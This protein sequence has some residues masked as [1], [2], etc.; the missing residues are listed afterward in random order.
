[1]AGGHH[2]GGGGG[3]GNPPVNGGTATIIMPTSAQIPGDVGVLP[4]GGKVE[5]L[6]SVANDNGAGVS[7]LAS[8]GTLSLNNTPKK[9]P[10]TYTAPGSITGTYSVVTISGQQPGL[11]GGASGAMASFQIVV[12]ATLNALPTAQIGGAAGIVFRIKGNSIGF[13]L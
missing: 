8:A 10:T 12:V 13:G 11:N 7:W 5:L 4:V 6:A 1:M 3:G 9:T 2:G